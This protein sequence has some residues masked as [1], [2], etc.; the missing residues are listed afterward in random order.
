MR[1]ERGQA[2]GTPGSRGR[3]ARALL[4]VAAVLVLL[5]AGLRA[6]LWLGSPA[7]A[8]VVAPGPAGFDDLVTS[9]AAAG[10]AAVLV[11]LCAGVALC[12]LVEAAGRRGGALEALAAATTPT[13]LRRMVAA[14]LSA[15]LVGA[16]ALAGTAA[17]ALAAPLDPHRAQA[18]AALVRALPV[19]D[20]DR[21]LSAPVLPAAELSSDLP[22]AELPEADRPVAH[23]GA[24]RSAA[25]QGV[26][27]SWTPD[28]PAAAPRRA[29]QPG[30][31]L[32]AS[33]PGP[34]AG[35]DQDDV[36]AVRPGDS[37]WT[38]AARHLGPGAT[39]AQVA[40][41]WPRWWAANR[42]VVGDDPDLLRPGQLLRPPPP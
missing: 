13:P 2:E 35:I 14:L 32:V 28:R 42:D 39:A 27:S 3:G 33:A 5:G 30:V 21:P 34:L 1:P 9:T 10:A 11:W 6:L 24:G 25:E 23:P 12:T 40:D 19:P 4:L 36:V 20:L 15:G 17:P 16:G 7:V 26:F 18:P 37:L 38:L 8:D 29:R 41:A 31:H 22:A